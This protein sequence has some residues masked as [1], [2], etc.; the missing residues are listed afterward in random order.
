MNKNLD[1]NKENYSAQE[2]DI[3][4]ALRPLSFDD[5][6]GQ[7][8]VLENLKVFVKAANMRHEALDH[9]LFHGPP[10]LG[11]T[12]LAHIL[13]NE[14]GVGIKITSGPVLDKPGD[15]AGLLT[16]LQERDV[17]F[18]DEIHRLSPVVEEY[19]YSAMEDYKIDIMIESGPNARTV[20]INL[21]PFTLIGA[22]TRSGL[23]TA[24]MRAR[25]GIQSR[26]QYYSTELL[27][28]IVQRSASILKVPI[29]ME[30]AIELA[31]RSRGT[32]RIANALLRRIRDFAQIKGNG[33]I[34]IA[35]TRFG[36]KAL[37]VDAH[38][39]DEMDNK[40]LS[41]LIDKF[42]G[43]P[44]GITTLATAVSESAETIEEV[45]EPFLIQEGFIVRT[46]RGREV[47][48]LA[49][50]HLGKVHPAKQGTL[51]D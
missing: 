42:K 25:F 29:S 37:N 14:L 46:P 41:T 7:E 10:G 18:I 22:T 1:P 28:D 12:T 48:E 44:V 27:A 31:S 26:L 13:A 3:E 50:K 40:I 32:P 11:K 24:P 23:L 49:Y 4:R 5:F 30:A 20:Q 38:G 51:F 33:Q 9:T 6:A 17:L 21:N 39:L 35:I 36:L 47:T 43:G 8:A 2:L 19:L 45:Y 34:D 16:N 15:L